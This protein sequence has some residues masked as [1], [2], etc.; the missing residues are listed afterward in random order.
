MKVTPTTSLNELQ[1]RVRAARPS[2]DQGS[3]ILVR[4]IQQSMRVEG[5]NVSVETVRAA[6]AVVRNEQPSR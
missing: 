1:A 4:S 5:H 6:V 3:N 2:H